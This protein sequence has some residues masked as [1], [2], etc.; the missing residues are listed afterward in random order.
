MDRRAENYVF[1]VNEMIKSKKKNVYKLCSCFLDIDKAFDIV[2][3]N[4]L[5]SF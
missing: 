4:A 5:Q 3:I 2:K 1:V